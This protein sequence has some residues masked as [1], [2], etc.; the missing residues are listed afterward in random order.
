[1]FLGLRIDGLVF[2][3]RFDIFDVDIDFLV[4]LVD[5][6][7]FALEVVIDGLVFGEELIKAGNRIG[8]MT[9]THIIY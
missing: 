8:S 5:F 3:V 6:V 9:V 2:I 7:E 4:A 1:M